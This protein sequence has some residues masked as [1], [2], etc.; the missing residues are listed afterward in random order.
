[1]DIEDNNKTTPLH[2]AAK[3]GFC[4]VFDLLLQSGADITL[5]DY[6]NRNALEIA[7]DKNKK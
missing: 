3:N 7:V 6:K 2:L 1:M 4:D 5:K